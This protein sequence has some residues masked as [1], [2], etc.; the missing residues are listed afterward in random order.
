M[1]INCN[2]C[3]YWGVSNEEHSIC[4]CC[5]THFGFDDYNKADDMGIIDRYGDFDAELVYPE[6]LKIWIDNGCEFFSA[7]KPDDWS[8]ENQL[9]NI[10]SD[11]EIKTILQEI[12]S[13]K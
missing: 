4:R 13:S 6:L 1:K 5:G 10:M 2:V 7:K 12:K 9:K 11:A 8:L 3:G